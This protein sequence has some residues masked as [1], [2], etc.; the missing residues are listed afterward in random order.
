VAFTINH[1]AA[2][3]LPAMLGYLYLAHPAAVFWLG[4]AMAGVSL[5]LAR[6]VPR[7][8][9]AGAETVLTGREAAFSAAE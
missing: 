8:P 6:L 4:A 5:I 1:I 2:V 3:F 9:E 7:H